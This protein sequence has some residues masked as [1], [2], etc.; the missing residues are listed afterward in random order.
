M[1]FDS[2]NPKCYTIKKNEEI[3]YIKTTKQDR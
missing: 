1:H 2:Q 3:K